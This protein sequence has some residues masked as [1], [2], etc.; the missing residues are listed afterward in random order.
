[1]LRAVTH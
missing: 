1:M